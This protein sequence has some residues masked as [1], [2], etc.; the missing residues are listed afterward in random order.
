MNI[1]RISKPGF[2]VIGKEGSSRDGEG[3][4]QRLWED[5]NSHFAE[6]AHLAKLR[7]DGSLAGVWGA[8]TDFSRSFQPW[9]NGFSE[10]YYLAGVECRDDANPPEGWTRWDVPGFEYLRAECDAPDVFSRM[11]EYLEKNGL[12]LAGA[13]QDHTDPATG[14][15]YMLFPVARLENV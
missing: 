2:C 14:K 9:E 8:M 7:E 15:N 5:A 6:V 12:T 4:V 1:E 10:G 11:L 3:F 13:V